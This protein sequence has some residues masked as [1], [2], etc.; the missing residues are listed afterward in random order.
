MQAGRRAFAVKGLAGTNLREDVLEPA[1]VSVG[2]FYHQFRDKTELLLAILGEHSETFR[3][4]LK[5]VHAPST[6]RS[7]LDVARDSYRMV[8]DMARERQEELRIGLR[9]RDSEDLR[10]RA[11]LREDRERWVESL[12][13]DYEA[14]LGRDELALDARLAAELVVALSLGSVARWLEAPP[15]ER[16][17]VRERL[18][19][20]LV[21]FTLGGLP[22]L[23]KAAPGSDRD[24][25][26][27]G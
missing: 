23:A 6:G 25:E 22:A 7:L 16:P 11:F 26:P 18:L 1:G 12:A 27:E 2:S 4:R 20:G 8:F 24:A 9:E 14:L 10:V 19:E 5:Q 15:E 17:A 13:E 3:L 21:H